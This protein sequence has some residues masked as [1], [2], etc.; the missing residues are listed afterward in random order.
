MLLNVWKRDQNAH[1][2]ASVCAVSAFAADAT[3]QTVGLLTLVAE[4]QN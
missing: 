4:K 2:L 3:A 1:I